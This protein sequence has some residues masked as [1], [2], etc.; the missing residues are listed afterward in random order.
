MNDAPAK[1]DEWFTMNITVRGNHI[2]VKVDGK[3]TADYH[4]PAGV[5]RDRA[6]AGRLLSRGTFAFQCHDPGSVVAYKDIR[7]KPL[8]E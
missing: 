1:D 3:V 4:E 8:A 6:F 2:V 7:V 5:K